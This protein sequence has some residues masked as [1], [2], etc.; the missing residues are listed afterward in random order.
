[1]IGRIL[2]DRAA[3]LPGKLARAALF[4]AVAA[5]GGAG[6]S[7][8]E[9]HLFPESPPGSRFADVDWTEPP[10]RVSVLDFENA[11]LLETPWPELASE[12]AP[13]ALMEPHPRPETLFTTATTVWT[14]SAVA[15]GVMQ[16]IGA[17][18]Q[19]GWVAW[20]VT[21]EG[22]FG[23][24]TYTGGAD[25]VSHFIISSGVSRLLYEAYTTLGHP[26]D[27]S[28]T[29]AVATA[30]MSGTMVEIMDAFSVYGF[31]FQDLTADALGSTAGALINRYE[32]QDMLGLRIGL[33]ETPIPASAIGSSVPTLGRSYNDEIYAAD[34]K[35][36]GLIRRMNRDPGF[37]RFFLTSFV[38]FTKGF[39]YD[40]P[41][42]TR[43]QEI[44]FE[45][46]L[47]FPEVLRALGVSEETWW[48][49]G[50]IAI[51]NFFRF[52]FTQIGVYYNLFDQKWYGPGAPRQYY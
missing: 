3:R 13:A 37:A 41:L 52:P 11:A 34:L 42:P 2:R 10:V 38:F 24:N 25:K 6:A 46:G 14:A 50:L 51:F 9:F 4:A 33:S 27:Q 36:G 43:Y 16:G 15:A 22:W 21:D 1:M 39:G 40:P 35:L 26:K 7:A 17:P 44:G 29:L 23:R 31:S 19:Y 20:N 18:L 30:F 48:G 5:L 49:T 28:F 45:V 47:N 12:A 32:L 8:E